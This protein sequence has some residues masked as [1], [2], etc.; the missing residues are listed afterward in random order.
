M[1]DISET[2]QAGLEHH[3]AGR[4]LQA[5]HM[6]RRVLQIHP[7][8][9]G[10]IH[11]LGLIAFQVGKPELAAEYLTEAIKIDAFRATYPADLGEIYRA[12]DKIPAAIDCYRKALALDPEM[13]E[14]HNNLGTL[15]Q[16]AG[17]P[18]EAIACFREALRLHPEYAEAHGNLGVVLQAQGQLAEAQAALEEAVKLTPEHADAYLRLGECLQVQGELLNALACYRKAMRLQPDLAVAHYRSAQV[19]LTQG[20]FANGWRDFEWRLKC[21]RSDGPSALQSSWNGA[22]LHGDR[23]L[24]HA[25]QGLGDTLQFARYVPLVAGQ[26]GGEVLFEV[27]P[28]LIRL[29]EQ[30]GFTN[31]LPAGET[32]S[33][34][35]VHAPLLSLPRLLGTTLETIPAPVPYLSASPDLVAQWRAKLAEFPG[36]KVG[37]AWQGDPAHALDR[38]R[39]IPLAEFQPLADAAGVRLV[40]LQKKHGLDQLAALGDRLGL[41]QFGDDV[42]EANGAFVDTA[43]IIKNLDLIIT[44]DTSIAHLAGALGAPVWLALSTAAD[45]RWLQNRDDSP[46]YPTM[47]L[48]RQTRLDDWS[49]VFARMADELTALVTESRAPAENT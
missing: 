46:W 34:C 26:R 41:V 49:T 13:A 27:P 7:R 31:L 16:T 40:S 39:S 9:A 33:D 3:R 20:D 5:E 25:E 37:I 42:D 32:A 45:W 38:F 19:R 17:S 36:F 48:F 24:I 29:L 22:D 8:H 10:A 11:L 21:P 28:Q 15:L 18:T 14:A 30:S 2:L 44:S 23:V 4:L 35:A 47:R 1:A 6:Y 43:A 12:Q